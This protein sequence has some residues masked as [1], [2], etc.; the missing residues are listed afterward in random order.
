VLPELFTIPFAASFQMMLLM[1]TGLDGISVET[2]RIA[3][4]LPAA[5]AAKVQFSIFGLEA[6]SQIPPPPMPALLPEKRQLP[7]QKGTFASYK[8]IPPPLSVALFPE[9]VELQM[10][11]APPELLY[12]PAPLPAL[13]EMNE[14]LLIETTPL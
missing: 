7:I 10:M 13:L 12:R 1:M 14:Q 6:E 3:L 4:P 2:F 8:N 11:L 5:F 9:K